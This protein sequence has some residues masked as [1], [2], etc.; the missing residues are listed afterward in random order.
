MSVLVCESVRSLHD[1]LCVRFHEQ[2]TVGCN[3]QKDKQAA[4]TA[5]HSTAQRSRV[6]GGAHEVCWCVYPYVNDDQLC[7]G[8]F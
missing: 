3:D 6:G 5:Q 7:V 4:Q 8:A 2:W 1:E